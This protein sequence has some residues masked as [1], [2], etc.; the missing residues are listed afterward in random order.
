MWCFHVVAVFLIQHYN[1]TLHISIETI[2]LYK[3]PD[4]S[5]NRWLVLPIA[6]FGLYLVLMRSILKAK[7]PIPL[8]VLL[9]TFIGLKIVIDVSV[10]LINGSFLPIGIKEYIDEKV[11]CSGHFTFRLWH[12]MFH[13]SFPYFHSNAFGKC[14]HYRL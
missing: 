13:F 2:P 14:I 11:E 7:E 9:I 12:K 4:V 3:R 8:P 5:F 1:L 10:T 6:G